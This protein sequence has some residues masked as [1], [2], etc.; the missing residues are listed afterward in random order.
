[1]PRARREL[2]SLAATP[3]YHCISRCVRRAFLW[4]EDSLTGRDYAHRK[5]WVIDRL[6]EL[7]AVF[8]IDVCAYAVMSNHYHLVLRVDTA[9][10]DAWTHEEIIGRWQALFSLPLLVERYHAG[11]PQGEAENETAQGIVEQW[12]TRLTDM[13]WFMRV[14]N[15]SLARRANAEDGC[16]GRFS[17][18]A[19]AL[20][21]LLHP[22][23]RGKDASR[24]RPCSTR[25]RCSRA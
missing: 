23:S 16:T 19:P 24:A 25:P 11:A 4:G 3:Y 22:C 21:Y 8:A 17:A 5:Q 12:R 15:E 7:A 2:V 6:S 18:I 1:M 9:R 10:A 13:S 14:L 20:L